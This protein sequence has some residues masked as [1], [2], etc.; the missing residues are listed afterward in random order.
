MNRFKVFL[1]A[2]LAGTGITA[3]AGGILFASLHRLVKAI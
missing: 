2:V 1:P 3:A